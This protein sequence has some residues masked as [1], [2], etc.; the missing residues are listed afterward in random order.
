[1]KNKE[2]VDTCRA[3]VQANNEKV[4]VMNSLQKDIEK[5]LKDSQNVIN[6]EAEKLEAKKYEL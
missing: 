5:I 1:M 6:Q 2:K 4:R 3:N